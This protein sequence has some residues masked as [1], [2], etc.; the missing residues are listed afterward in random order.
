MLSTK[1]WYYVGN[2]V[3]NVNGVEL[4]R[5]KKKRRNSIDGSIGGV[6]GGIRDAS[7]GT[8]GLPDN[9]RSDG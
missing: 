2:E 1:M 9:S 6:L 3:Q 4:F 5:F 8:F 7:G